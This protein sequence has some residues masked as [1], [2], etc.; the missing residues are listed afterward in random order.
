MENVILL[1]KL[2]IQSYD[3][4]GDF[5]FKFLLGQL[6]TTHKSGYIWKEN[7]LSCYLLMHF[8]NNFFIE[9]D[10]KRIEGSA[11]DFVLHSPNGNYAHGSRCEHEGFINDWFFFSADEEDM[12]FLKDLPYNKPISGGDG[13]IFSKFLSEILSENIH[14]DELSPLLI[15]NLIFHMLSVLRRTEAKN[16][17]YKF[18]NESHREM[19]QIRL[20][21][22]KHC[23]EKLNLKSMA[24]ATGYSVS[25]FCALYKKLFNISPIDDLLNARLEM[26]KKLLA[27]KNHK[28]SEIADL[29]GFSSIYHFSKFFKNKTGKNPSEY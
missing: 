13:K 29:C 27:L 21:I 5:L 18:K 12:D 3:F 2:F 1:L 19:Y 7:N 10:G 8:R 28:I 11:G 9:V 26:A 6:K 4:G 22:H 14:N 15:S 20:H 25:H 16:N 24:K 23:D 17:I